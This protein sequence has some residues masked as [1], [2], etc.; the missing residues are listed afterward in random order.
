MGSS[1]TLELSSLD[2]SSGFVLNGVTA[3]DRSGFSVSAAGDG[4]DDL[5]IGAY[6]ADP[7]GNESGASYVVFG[8][9]G[10][11]QQRH[12]G[13]VCSLDGS[14]GFVLNGVTTGDFS[15]RSVSAAGDVNGDGIDDLLIGAFS[16]D[17]NGSSSGASYVVFGAS[18]VG[19]SG[20]LELSSLDGSNG[21]VLNGVT[22][23]DNSDRE[24]APDQ[25]GRSVS[26]AGDVNGDGIDDLLIGAFGADPNGSDSGASY[27][28]FGAISGDPVINSPATAS[29]A[30][31]QLS[32]IDVQATDNTDAEGAG[33]V[34][35]LSGGADQAL[36]DIDANTGVV[37]FMTAPD[38]ENPT[39]A[40]TDNNYDFQ[41]TVTD[42]DGLTA[43]QDIVITVTDVNETTGPTITSSNTASVPENQTSAID[44]DATDNSNSEGPSLI[45]SIS[46]GADAALFTIDDE[47]G[48][49]T[50]NAAPDFETPGDAGADN[51]Y[52]IQVTVTDIRR[53]NRCAGHC[54]H[55]H[56]RG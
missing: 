55:R 18:G 42:S 15:G 22:T 19:S 20:T 25:S 48:V 35:T 23:V 29:V 41:V 16:A 56:R 24:T 46:G 14:N 21:F 34:F 38:F 49:V 17:P 11:G 30:E 51:D 47:S 10:G 36:F 54:H 13:V 1:G 31:N 32:A 26:A 28:V 39:D 12:A 50:F 6:R 52:D 53:T 4:I 8:A 3:Y 33:L 5:L 27:V 37:T 43:V 44:V 40:G 7:N 45:Y 2:G 9:S